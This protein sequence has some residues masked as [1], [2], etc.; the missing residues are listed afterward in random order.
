MTASSWQLAWLRSSK[1]IMIVKLE[2]VIRLLTQL[3]FDGYT[4]CPASSVNKSKIEYP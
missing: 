2:V 4:L 3:E 1:M